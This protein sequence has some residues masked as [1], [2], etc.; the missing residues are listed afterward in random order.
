MGRSAAKKQGKVREFHSSS[1][2]RLLSL[3]LRWIMSKL[4][5]CS[6]GMFEGCKHE[7]IKLPL[8][9]DDFVRPPGTLVPEGLIFYP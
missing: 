2:G 3:L 7:H 4:V 5:V 8:C 6:L 9:Y 1:R